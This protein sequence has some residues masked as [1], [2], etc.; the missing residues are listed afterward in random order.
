LI[1]NAKHVLFQIA[2]YASKT[3]PNV[4]SALTI[5]TTMKMAVNP[6]SIEIAAPAA[7]MAHAQHAYPTIFLHKTAA[8]S[9]PYNSATSA[10]LYKFV[11]NVTYL[12]HGMPAP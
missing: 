3:Y 1:T 4:S 12:I 6:V 9:V 2:K 8:K 5:T 11:N 10:K 7:A